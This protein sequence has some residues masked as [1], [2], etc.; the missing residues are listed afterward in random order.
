M[1]N[2]SNNNIVK[3]MA[4]DSVHQLVAIYYFKQGVS[5]ADVVATLKSSN[6]VVAIKGVQY[7]LQASSVASILTGLVIAHPSAKT[8]LSVV[9]NGTTPVVPVIEV[10]E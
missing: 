9:D 10:A 7:H 4:G 1:Y 8:K 3:A 2:N 5:P 6:Y